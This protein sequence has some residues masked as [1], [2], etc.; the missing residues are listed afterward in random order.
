[1]IVTKRNAGVLA[2]LR[3]LGSLLGIGALI[4][5]LAIT[6][7]GTVAA[8]DRDPAVEFGS[9]LYS[10]GN[11]SPR[12][13]WSDGTTMWVADDA[14]DKLYAYS[15]EEKTR[16]PTRD[17][18]GLKAAGNEDPAGIW[19]DGTTLWVADG[20]DDKI[21]AYLTGSRAWDPDQDFDTL[22]AP[23]NRD[24][25]GIW[26]DGATLWV[27]DD[28]DDK[29]Y[30][31]DLATRARVTGRDFDTLTAAGNNDPRGIWSD[32]ATMWVA[33]TVDDKIYAYDLATKARVPAREFE[34]LQGAG[35]NHP[36]GIWSDGATMWVAD[37]FVGTRIGTS[38]CCT[39]VYEQDGI[40]AYDMPEGTAPVEPTDPVADPAAFDRDPAVEFGSSLYS[41]GN[42]SPRG[43]WSDGTTMW[44]ADDADDKLYAY[45]LEEKTRVPTRDFDGLK[46]AGN[47]DPA[48]IWSDGTTLWVADGVDDKIYA[49]LTGSRAWDPDQDFD[50]LRAPGNRDPA[51]IW[52]DGATL[53]VADDGDDKIY[54]YDL[55]T[56][57][58]V[59]GRDFDTLTAAGNNDPRGIWSD[60]AT[61]WVA[62]TVDDKIYAYDLATKARVPAREFETL[63]GAGNNHPRGIWSDGA[64]MWVADYFV[65]TRI[66]TSGCCTPVY[67]QDGIFAYDMP[68]GT[69]PVEPTDPVADPAAFDRDPAVEFG[70]SL[71]SA[72]N[73]SPRG[74]W[75]DG[76][77]M[78]VAD[79]A[80]DK[81]YAYGLEEKT[82]VPTRDFDGLKAAGNED[83]AG[84]WSDGTT[85]WVADGVDDKIYAYLT[86]SRAWDPD[87]D[88]DTLRAPGNRDPAGIWSDGATLWVA[89]DG[90]DKI[91]AYDLATRARVT[92][93]D[94]DTLT[95]AGNNDPRGIWSD[96]ATMWVADTVD[97]K[98]YAYDLATKA[99]VPARE[100]ETLQGAGNNHPR[101]IWSDGAT[102]WVAD[103]FVGTRIGTSGCCTPVY[104]QDGIF[105]YDMP[106]GT[107]PV[108]PT[109]PVADP[110]AFDRDPAVEFGSSLYSAGNHSPRGL[111]SDGTTMWVADDADD[112][113][114]AYG[115]EEKTR[116]PTRDFDGL[117]AAGNEDPAGIWSDGTT[118]W[119][120]DWVDDKLYAYDFAGKQ[121]VPAQD[122]DTLRAPGNRDPRG[123][124]SDGAT[125][126]VADT[127]DRKI[128]AYDLATKARV[129]AREVDTLQNAGNFYRMGIWSD[130]TT[131][132]VADIGDRKIYAYDL[133]TKARVPAREFETL[134]NAGNRDPT[135]IWS[136]G[137]T[138]WVADYFVGTRIG[139]SGCCTPVYEQDGIFAYNMPPNLPPGVA[140]IGSVS[141]GAG[142]LTVS[143]SARSGD[144]SGI[145]A[146]DLRYIPTNADET[147]DTNWTVEE[148]V[149]TTGSGSLQYV[150]TGLT[151][152]T[153]YD[154]QVRA[155]NS[156]GDG[157]W[158]A[159]AT[160]TPQ[161]RESS[162]TAIRSFSPT[163]VMPG[164]EVTVTVA[165]AN[166][167]IA[168]GLKET[169]PEGFAYKAMSSSLDDNQV[170]VDG[171][172][173]QFT[174]IGGSESITYIV[175]A[176]SV[177]GSHTFSG[178]LRDSDRV[179]VPVGG[180]LS[181]TVGT[182][183]S[184]TVTTTATAPVRL[185]TSVPV[186][187]TFS[188]PVSGF[189]VDDIGVAN[190][191][192]GNFTGSGAVYTFD[193]TPNAIGR[194]TVD[195][196]DDAATD[197]G[198]NGNTAAS[199]LSLGIPYD[200]DGD[201]AIGKSEVIAAI[202][203]YL[204]GEG[205]EAISKPEV[206]RLINLYLFG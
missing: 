170:M 74:L 156:A 141:A 62:D 164:G 59:T 31:Y 12:G 136:D 129:P 36:R 130:G 174:L 39:P 30:A 23:G 61:M 187:A 206:I 113:L 4:L 149:W 57:A 3:L 99:R 186:T 200:D 18:D 102:M 29:I 79:D 195:I 128:Y 131:M 183:L 176:S 202:N 148:D 133:A 117:K 185:G 166:Y 7:T 120:A 137:A 93:R 14:D 103:Y 83:P 201:G 90:D 47:E 144:A 135:G 197:D 87:Q 160:G 88:F 152:G 6:A 76:T 139:T 26:S 70:S 50:T 119:V 94:F 191:A 194:V 60:G 188:A 86:G 165:V 127:G 71:Y 172:T 196:T 73:H 72:G 173:V 163:S 171:Q 37:Y 169:L 95:A 192:V 180:A 38:G 16:V 161:Q 1:M 114:Y 147:A 2:V 43:L 51:G 82:R 64:T 19:S 140:A 126:W 44:V 9:S 118:L 138:M 145:T 80:D 77:T 42:H 146:Y 177:E 115:L 28:G 112:K 20:V 49:Y 65:G 124:W 175:T 8:F 68:E 109:D 55:A 198:G 153:Q 46:A 40:F 159:T 10:A 13:L 158:S 205:D 96:G 106:E 22:R 78:W 104:E 81:L 67:E 75:S 21:Y 155:V 100:F 168:G 143:W 35:N 184:V 54:A 34:T 105:A 85:L 108:E 179:E 58:R 98:I 69:A 5:A 52:S 15:L 25:A 132:W 32:G 122:F 193:V 53:W 189:T 101:G 33:D 24:P 48:G 84:I 182:E 89:D 157:P 66:G 17:F 190:G 91:Y 203:D 97:D 123:I 27:A 151:G 134:Q 56:R 154:L 63:Q 199:Q 111:W 107:A 142:S 181:I 178:V 92:G 150:L 125:M 167:G 110:A 204:F 41:A 121:P 11:H 45:G 116:V 162:A